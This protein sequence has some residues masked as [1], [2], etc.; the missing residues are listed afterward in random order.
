MS[1]MGSYFS[2]NYPASDSRDTRT[3]AC[4][5]NLSLTLIFHAGVSGMFASTPGLHWKGGVKNQE[6]FLPP[7]DGCK[8]GVFSTRDSFGEHE[9]S[10]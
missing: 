2:Y 3:D 7:G 6:V 10:I 9:T 1:V 4:S 5:I 8:G